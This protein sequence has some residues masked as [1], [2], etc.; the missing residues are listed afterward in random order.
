MYGA[1]SFAIAPYWEMNLTRSVFDPNMALLFDIVDPLSYADVC[2]QTN[3][4][5]IICMRACFGVIFS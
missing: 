4:S 3:A 2:S 1:Y 5:M